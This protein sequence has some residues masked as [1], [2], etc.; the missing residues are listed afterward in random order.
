M[1]TAVDYS[2]IRLDDIYATLRVDV[3]T[4]QWQV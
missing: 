2:D 1:P 3:A 4:A